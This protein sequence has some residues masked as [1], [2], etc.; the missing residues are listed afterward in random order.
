MSAKFPRG[1]GGGGQTHSQP[2]VYKVNVLKYRTVV[3]LPK[4][5]RPQKGSSLCCK[6]EMD[7]AHNNDDNTCKQF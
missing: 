4:R 7:K 6:G 5:H 2:S 3:K 1:G